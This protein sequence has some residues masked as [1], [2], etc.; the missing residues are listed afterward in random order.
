MPLSH[1]KALAN[2]LAELVLP[3]PLSPENKYACPNLSLSSA[4]E[5]ELA[6]MSWP[7]NSL[8]FLGRYFR[9]RACIYDLWIYL[10][11]NI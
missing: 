1:S 2:I 10:V 5:S 3:L 8:K 9:A 6:M 4:R 7:I 11:F